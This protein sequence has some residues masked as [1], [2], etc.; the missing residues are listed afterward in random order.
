M[1]AHRFALH[2]LRRDTGNQQFCIFRVLCAGLLLLVLLTGLAIAKT[3]PSCGTENRDDAQFCK[4]CGARLPAPVERSAPAIPRVRAEVTVSG[5]TV[6]ITSEPSGATVYID[7][8]S[9]GTTPLELTGLNP[10]RHEITV[11]RSGYRDYSSTFTISGS[12]GTI[13]VTTEPVGAEIWVDGE[14]RGNTTANGL[15]IPRLSFGS[16][17]VVAR[18]SG[19]AEAR[20]DLNLS[21]AGP[22]PVHLRLGQGRGYL[23]IES[24]PPRAMVVANGRRLGLTN[25]TFELAPNRYVLTLQRRGYQDWL[26]YADVVV[27]ETAYITEQLIRAPGR[28]LPFLVAGGLGIVA[29]GFGALR[30]EAEYASYRKA[31]NAADAQKY[32]QATQQW[33]TFRNVALGVG[34][35]MCTVYFVVRW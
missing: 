23:R 14:F 35:A 21:S 30:G 34:T 27:G 19:F 5:S 4:S 31:T 10:G 25:A 33:D 26:G 6:S 28:K 18:L 22:I 7:G 15:T 13:L 2:A 1:H 24:E 12:A 11:S 20:R 3:C 9:R 32:R 29:A 16:H 17:S 8:V